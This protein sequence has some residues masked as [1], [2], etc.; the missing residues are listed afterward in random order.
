MRIKFQQYKTLPGTVTG[1]LAVSFFVTGCHTGS[2]P[3][4][5]PK[6]FTRKETAGSGTDQVSQSKTKKEKTGIPR[7]N[8]KA[9]ELQSEK[10]TDTDRKDRKLMTS[11]R[12][13]FARPA[14][15]AEDKNSHCGQIRFTLGQAGMNR[16][17]LPLTRGQQNTVIQARQSLPQQALPAHQP[18]LSCPAEPCIAGIFDNGTERFALVRWQ[19][20]QG[21]FRS[22]ESLGNGYYVKEITAQSVMLAPEKDS[23]GT[24]SI[25]LTMK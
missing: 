23:T 19:Q 11:T 21:I 1:L 10:L 4:P 14:A 16:E 18:V 22:G 20:V 9:A 13:P 24:N 3:A 8:V 6:A 25:T 5:V 7:Y 12:D 17:Q 15:L 2:E